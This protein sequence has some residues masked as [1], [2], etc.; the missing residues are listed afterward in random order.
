MKLA[1]VV[2]RFGTEIAGGS[3]AHCR[4]I[5]ERLAV[6]HAVTIL[7]T[8][9]KDHVTWR[10]AYPAGESTIGPL[11]VLRFR[12][13]RQRSLHDFADISDIVS[14]PGASQAVQEQWFRANGPETPEL[15]TY[16]EEHGRDYDLVLFWAF[17]YYQSFFGMPIV[18]DRAVLL[19]TAEDDPVIRLD[20]LGRYFTKPAGLVFLTPEEQRLVEHR[21][22]GPIGP[23]CVIGSGL[24]PPVPPP[25]VDL[26]ERGVTPPYALYLGRIDPNKGC[27]SLIRYFTRWA[28]RAD[29]RV[30]LVLAGPANM[31]IPPHAQL[32]PL[33]FVSEDIREAL[34]ASATLL[35]VPSPFESL[36]MVLLEAWNHAVPGL[37]NGRCL[38]LKGQAQRS[39]GALYYRNFDEF[40]GA[41]NV[42]LRR[43]E[44]A[45]DLGR[46]GLAYVD[47]LYRWPHVMAM[48]EAFLAALAFKAAQPPSTP[49]ARLTAAIP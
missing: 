6:K 5:A 2:H 38:V 42:L 44:L 3:E 20:I 12:V 49:V 45:R 10:N 1:C 39:G 48:L 19:P 33:G 35:V 21:A 36:S 34:L 17:R 47:R 28:D 31:P 15:L 25:D 4:G 46:S 27:E 22:D 24:E 30:P 16:L 32:K 7:T 41:L 26:T 43:P 8:T 37:V 14:S 13:T 23:S 40:S 11:R 9:A 29:A 18:A